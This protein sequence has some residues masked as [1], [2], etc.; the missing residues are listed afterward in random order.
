MP[1]DRGKPQPISWTSDAL[2][3]E[4]GPP[5]VDLQGPEEEGVLKIPQSYSKGAPEWLHKLSL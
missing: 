3:W 5:G 1:A 4:W 2:A